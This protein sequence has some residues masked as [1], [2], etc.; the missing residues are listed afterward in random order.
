[1]QDDA[2]EIESNRMASSKLKEKV[3]TGN[4]H[5]KRFRE[6]AG[7]SGSRKSIE[8]K[9][10]DMAKIIKELS[11]KISGMELD[12]SK[13]DPFARRDF[14]RNPNPQIQQRLVKNEDIGNQQ[15]QKTLS[16]L[17]MH[18]ILRDFMKI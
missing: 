14:K 5:T 17:M 9:M 18:K 6:Q 2:I 8:D 7:T 11:N 12:Q 4:K 10:D 16:K 13:P 1:M 15:R 3:E